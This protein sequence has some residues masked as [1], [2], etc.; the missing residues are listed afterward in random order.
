MG[1]NAP[2]LEDHV[3]V[4]VELGVLERRAEHARATLLLMALGG[5]PRGAM[6]CGHLV[7]DLKLPAR[8]ETE[9]A[10]YELGRRVRGCDRGE[11]SVILLATSGGWLQGCAHVGL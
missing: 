5:G 8:C 10:R 11:V 4:V 9:G 1:E 2:K 3:R 7:L 6:G